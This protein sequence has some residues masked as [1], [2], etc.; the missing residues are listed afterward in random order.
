MNIIHR[1]A[2]NRTLRRQFM[3]PNRNLYVTRQGD[4]IEVVFVR[5]AP[6]PRDERL[7]IHLTREE[8]TALHAQLTARLAEPTQLTRARNE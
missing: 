2:G 5:E 8:A 6:E 3:A 1:N 7:E 4:T